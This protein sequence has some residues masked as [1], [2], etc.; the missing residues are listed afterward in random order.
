MATVRPPSNIKVAP[1]LRNPNHYSDS[2]RKNSVTN[3]TV[4]IDLD[5]ACTSFQLTG[6]RELLEGS[7][8]SHNLGILIC[9]ANVEWF[10]LV[11]EILETTK[12]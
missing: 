2:K 11:H 7:A 3:K 8:T 10:I 6:T 9:T 12:L 4:S 1:S 5:I